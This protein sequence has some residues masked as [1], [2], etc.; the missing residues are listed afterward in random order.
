MASL[1]LPFLLLQPSNCKFDT[2][3]SQTK[4]YGFDRYNLARASHGGDSQPQMHINSRA[5]LMNQT[6]ASSKTFE[7]IIAK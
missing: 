3:L 5:S 4:I 2:S 7:K 1:N 6:K